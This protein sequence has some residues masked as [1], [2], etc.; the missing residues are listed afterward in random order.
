MTYGLNRGSRRALAATT[1]VML[2]AVVAGC[3]SSGSTTAGGETTK[4]HAT[5]MASERSNPN[6]G[7]GVTETST[8]AVS[9]SQ[10]KSESR[11]GKPPGATG[12]TSSSAGRPP[13]TTKSGT[14]S[15]TSAARP[16]RTTKSGAPSTTTPT[17]EP[18]PGLQTVAEITAACGS[19]PPVASLP[20]T[21][22]RLDTE[23]ALAILQRVSGLRS[24]FAEALAPGSAPQSTST[25]STAGGGGGGGAP[26]VVSLPL[27]RLA[28]MTAVIT[29]LLQ[30]SLRSSSG[31]QALRLRQAVAQ[32]VALASGA[33]I[34]SCAV[35]PA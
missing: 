9:G 26:S 3:G 35:I 8:I 31:Q 29:Q 2:A 1:V 22:T 16:P 15:T 30:M 19:L 28:D 18:S 7:G 27:Q 14:R 24:I 33:G 34:P 32:Q 6:T 10:T 17:V 4:P 13:R 23:A 25:T 12:E 21:G 5:P 20:S 11:V